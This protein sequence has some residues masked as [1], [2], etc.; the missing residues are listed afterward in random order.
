MSQGKIRVQVCAL[1]E[2]SFHLEIHCATLGTWSQSAR[3]DYENKTKDLS[4]EGR[5]K[6]RL[7]LMAQ[8]GTI[9]KEEVKGVSPVM[10]MNRIEKVIKQMVSSTSTIHG[11]TLMLTGIDNWY[12]ARSP[13]FAAIRYQGLHGR[14]SFSKG[15]KRCTD[16]H[17]TRS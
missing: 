12:F 13:R 2:V 15:S 9:V 14:R 1:T 17:A 4:D 16:R 11:W 5:E 10:R 6:F 3:I 7:E 8:L